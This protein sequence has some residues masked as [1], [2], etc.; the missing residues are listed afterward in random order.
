MFALLAAIVAVGIALAIVSAARQAL[1]A[2]A[3]SPTPSC[4]GCSPCRHACQ[5]KADA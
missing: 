3:E 1:L 2:K 4:C 5:R